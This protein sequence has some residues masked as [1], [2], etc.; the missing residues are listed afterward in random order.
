VG[1]PFSSG[2]DSTGIGTDT[3]FS[4]AG[5]FVSFD[6]SGNAIGASGLSDTGGAL[7]PDGT[8]YGP[9]ASLAPAVPS[10]GSGGSAND[11]S[12]FTNPPATANPNN[13]ALY[14]SGA[15]GPGPS[16]AGPPKPSGGLNATANNPVNT[17]Q[18]GQP[19][20]SLGA[21][22]NNALNDAFKA[23]VVSQGGTTTAAGRGGVVTSS[24]A[25]A[26]VLAS[27]ASS[28]ASVAAPGLSSITSGN[29]LLILLAVVAIIVVIFVM[30]K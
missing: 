15:S 14:G 25:G 1:L 27:Q 7:V 24:G 2:L 17:T 16:G 4:D 23:Y 30:K 11:A 18:A 12:V 20:A 5:L 26:K 10:V 29:G 6:A 8:I 28:L 22:I 9:S 19:N 3:D 21:E 13:P